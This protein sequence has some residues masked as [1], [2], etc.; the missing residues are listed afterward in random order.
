MCFCNLDEQTFF[1]YQNEDLTMTY[2]YRPP[3]QLN[4]V[5]SVRR[6]PQSLCNNPHKKSGLCTAAA[7]D[8]D[9]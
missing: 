1:F 6:A 7:V 2:D 9:Y 4:N 5:T 3:L 8:A